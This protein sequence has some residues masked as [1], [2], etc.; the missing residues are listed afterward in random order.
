MALPRVHA[1][2]ILAL[3]AA[4]ILPVM[5]CASGTDTVAEDE[6]EAAPPEAVA[7]VAGL[8]E[9]EDASIASLNPDFF[10]ADAS[11]RKSRVRKNIRN[12]T[13][14]ER[15]DY[16]NA[17]LKLKKTRSPYDNSLSYYDQFVAWH[18]TLNLCEFG[19]PLPMQMGHG[20]PIF[21]PWHRVFTLLF[22]TALQQVSGKPITVPYWDWA[23]TPDHDQ[24]VVFADDFMGGAGDPMDNYAVKTGPFR[25]GKWTLNVEPPGTRWA[26]FVTSYLTR[27]LGMTPFPL[28]TQADV[29]LMMSTTVYDIPPY[30]HTST[31]GASFRNTL[32]G[33]R[34][35]GPPLMMECTEDGTMPIP[36]NGSGL[37]NGIHAW[38]GGPF[39]NGTMVLPTS[40]NDPVFF[41][42]H[43]QVDRLWA[44]WQAEHGVDSYEPASGDPDIDA[45]AVMMPFDHYGIH[46]TPAKVAS[47]K[48]LGYRYQ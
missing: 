22:E 5:G 21:L 29:D 47:I 8:A 13:S 41:L 39:T 43:S 15:K 38:V 9:G 31:F 26:P 36:I 7:V 32:E 30:D 46:V 10:S 44:Q 19:Q 24:S 48:K 16:V 12:L 1:A 2:A 37:H 45:N 42:H 34:G 40:P 35:D 6:L 3:A 23:T 18:V 11:R 17:V 25:K 28:P 14:T 27:F 20:S 33:N 4:Q